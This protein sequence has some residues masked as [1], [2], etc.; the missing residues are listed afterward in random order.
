M[1]HSPSGMHPHNGPRDNGHGSGYGPQD[2]R[3]PI[4]PERRGQSPPG[5][6]QLHNDGPIHNNNGPGGFRG[7]PSGM[8]P[9]HVLGGMAQSLNG[10]ASHGNNTNNNDG[11][12][13]NSMMQNQQCQPQHMVPV[14]QSINGGMQNMNMNASNNGNIPR[15]GIQSMS[16]SLNGANSQSRMNRSTNGMNRSRNG[17]DQSNNR[18]IQSMSASLNG[19]QNVNNGASN[20]H[21]AMMNNNM[22]VQHPQQHL[23]I[24]SMSASLNGM[25]QMNAEK[26]MSQ[27]MNGMQGGYGGQHQGP[28]HHQGG[29]EPMGMPMNRSMNGM[30]NMQHSHNGGDFRHQQQHHGMNQMSASQNGM[31]NMNAS[32]NGMPNMNAS[33]QGGGFHPPQHQGGGHPLQGMSQSLM[34]QSLNGLQ[35][36]PYGGDG[37]RRA[38]STQMPN[39]NMNMNMMNRSMNGSMN[40]SMNGNMNASMNGSINGNMNASNNGVPSANLL[41]QVSNLANLANRSG[42]ADD[43]NMMQHLQ[44]GGSNTS[45]LSMKLMEAMKRTA[46]SRK[47]I[48]DLN[49]AAMLRGDLKSPL[50]STKKSVVKAR[51]KAGRHSYTKS[52]SEASNSRELKKAQKA[53]MA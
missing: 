31:P 28:H 33:N 40:A 17:M 36:P 14:S 35:N 45:K 53:V 7:G 34:S 51:R 29:P 41:N 19:M 38:M 11:S 22:M 32:Q 1:S 9:Q 18:G 13:G 42:G 25:Q 47:L 16:E 10:M 30:Q 5:M 23:G 8:P 2:R 24:Q 39:M 3:H 6:A 21:N 43:L 44:G 48:K 52:I 12:M 46:N 4:H 15:L 26:I 37:H 20:G 49:I 27:S 50:S